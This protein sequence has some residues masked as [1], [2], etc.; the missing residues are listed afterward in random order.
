MHLSSE[1]KCIQSENRWKGGFL[2]PVRTV[3][4]FSMCR[5]HRN[6]M[7]CSGGKQGDKNCE[8]VYYCITLQCRR[9]WSENHSNNKI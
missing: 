6:G 1:L 5:S 7:R 8:A 4:I 3:D 2:C 9:E